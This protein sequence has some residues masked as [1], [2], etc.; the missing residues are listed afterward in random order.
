MITK[1]VD[2]C[3]S[4]IRRIFALFGILIA[5]A[6]GVGVIL[7]LFIDDIPLGDPSPELTA[8]PSQPYL[9]MHTHVAGIGAGDSGCFVSDELR[10]SY[11]FNFYLKAFDTNTEEV[12]QQGDRIV[13]A[14]LSQRVTESRFVSQAVVLA[15]DGVIGEDGTLS[16]ERT[17]VYVP[18]DYVA[19]ETGLYD[20][21][22]FGASINPHRPDALERLE[23]VAK[24]GAV[25]IK[26]IPSIMNIDPS[27]SRLVPF[28]KRM[29]ALGLPLLTHA[30]NER[31]FAHAN[32]ELGDPVRL[33]LPLSFG[34][35]V[36][37]A[38][39]ASTGEADGVSYFYRIMPMFERFP[40]LY[41]DV[42]SLTQIN[43]LG[44]LAKALKDNSLSN[45]MLYGSDW[46]LQFFPLVSPWY[47]LRHISLADAQFISREKN[48]LD[49]D[50]LI[51][52]AMGLPETVF[53]R[54]RT[55][56]SSP[57]SDPAAENSSDPS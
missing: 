50:V 33:T 27:D 57:P 10:N 4:I 21:L 30:G 31:S 39:I 20:N 25:L 8:V 53:Q 18:N 2:F 1:F 6:I 52:K 28:Y 7:L 12:K 44:Y 49:R 32:D 29:A 54:S 22:L 55:L 19:R 14:K 5:S 45:R 13:F 24:Q 11:K 48:V 16:K 41:T 47:Q 51:K 43:K 15:L 36:I 40:N 35:T 42:S 46:P 9:D 37:A 26:W 23:R 3:F 34:V 38:H 17:Q 56:I